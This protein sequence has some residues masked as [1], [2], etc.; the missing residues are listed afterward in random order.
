[1]VACQL[2]FPFDG[3]DDGLAD[4]ADASAFPADA[5]LADA[6]DA[7]AA[8][9][10]SDATATRDADAAATEAAPPLTLA[11]GRIQPAEIVVDDTYVYWVEFGADGGVYRTR[12]DGS[13]LGAVTTVA[14]HQDFPVDLGVDDAGV[15]WA[16]QSASGLPLGSPDAGTIMRAAKDGSGVPATLLSQVGF[17]NRVAL[18]DTRVYFTLEI[19][20]NGA[21]WSVPKTGGAV[22][23]HASGIDFPGGLGVDDA[24]VYFTVEGS[25]DTVTDDGVMRAPKT[26]CDGSPS[27]SVL[28]TPAAQPPVNPFE[29]RLDDTY[30]YW[31]QRWVNE[32]NNVGI[33][34]MLKT[35]GD[36]DTLHITTDQ[37]ERVG[38]SLE[39]AQLF[40]TERAP[41]GT[42]YEA[43]LGNDT[44]ETLLLL[45]GEQAEPQ[46]IVADSTTVY[47]TD[48]SGGA[49]MSSAR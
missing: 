10:A 48:F 24:F 5:A 33:F 45:D 29:L 39:G 26:G 49:V 20:G 17:P 4:A 11:S 9:D 47:W 41:V 37:C 7:T 22:L 6:A 15:Y 34:R 19:V 35:G 8:T 30:V 16:T 38:L 12:K 21:V 14:A 23:V 44:L 42:V 32:D 18:D 43:T 31:G 2:A 46:G 40:F 28:L 36:V 25:D 27:C 1:M 3:Y 13:D